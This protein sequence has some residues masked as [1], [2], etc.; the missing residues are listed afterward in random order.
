MAAE[1]AR[2]IDDP[3]RLAGRREE[4]LARARELIGVRGLIARILAEMNIPA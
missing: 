1:A 3:V 4:A 2:L